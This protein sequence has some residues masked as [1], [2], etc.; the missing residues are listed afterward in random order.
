MACSI[1]QSESGESTRI[2]QTMRMKESGCSSHRLVNSGHL[3]WCV[4]VVVGLCGN[5]PQSVV[6]RIER[7][8]TNCNIGRTDEFVLLD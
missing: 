4:V 7:R 1:Y 5:G 3:I 2:Y 6:D 8:I